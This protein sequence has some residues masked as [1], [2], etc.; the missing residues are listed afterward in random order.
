MSRAGRTE[1]GVLGSVR[2]RRTHDRDI[3]VSPQLQ[4]LPEGATHM[5]DGSHHAQTGPFPAKHL[6]VSHAFETRLGNTR[7]CRK[8]I[9]SIA[10]QIAPTPE[11]KRSREIP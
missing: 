2:G 6:I 4:V 11:M 7:Q 8:H 1:C 3:I 5:I 10:I 9:Y